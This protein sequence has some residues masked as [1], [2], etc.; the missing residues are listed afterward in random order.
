MRW[1]WPKTLRR[2][3]P[4]RLI[5]G[6]GTARRDKAGHFQDGGTVLDTE[7]TPVGIDSVRY[8][9]PDRPRWGRPLF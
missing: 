5:R 7:G 4:D 8:R 2:P 1:R 9:T 3:L 6:S